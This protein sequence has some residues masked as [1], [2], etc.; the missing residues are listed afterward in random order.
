MNSPA[1]KR[2]W[3]DCGLKNKNT[4]GK[5]IN[6]IQIEDVSFERVSFKIELPVSE[7]GFCVFECV[8]ELTISVNLKQ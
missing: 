3:Y 4:Q 5:L 7:D 2:S 8:G 1:I 6:E